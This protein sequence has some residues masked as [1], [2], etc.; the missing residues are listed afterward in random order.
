MVNISQTIEKKVGGF[1]GFGKT[2]FSATMTF[3][4][5]Q[6]YVGEQAQVRMQVDNSNCEK[7]IR[8]FKCKIMRKFKLEAGPASEILPSVF[9]INNGAVKSKHK[10]YIAQKK[11]PSGCKAGQKVDTV[12]GIDF[13]TVDSNS[14]RNHG[15]IEWGPYEDALNGQITPS[16][17]GKSFKVKYFLLAFVHHDAWNEFGEGYCVK[18]PIKIMQPPT[19][20][21]APVPI[22]QA[23]QGWQPQI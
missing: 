12:I 6:F 13:P 2:S 7:D 23:P 21:F 5:N 16:V 14:L 17:Y 22:M 4:K 3:S 8:N 1:L 11:F 15:I 10:T 19:V 9:D 20:V 18:V